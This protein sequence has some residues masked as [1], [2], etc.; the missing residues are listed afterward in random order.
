VALDLCN[1]E[2]LRYIIPKILKI[3][4]FGSHYKL[5]FLFPQAMRQ[6]DQIF[7]GTELLGQWLMSMCGEILC[8]FFI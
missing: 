5:K 8:W 2:G 1:C 6:I 4:G 3:F 7:R